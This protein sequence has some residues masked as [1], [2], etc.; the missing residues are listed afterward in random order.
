MIWDSFSRILAEMSPTGFAR[1]FGNYMVS[2]LLRRNELNAVI[3]RLLYPNLFST[4]KSDLI[5]VRLVIH[6]LSS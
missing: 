5:S 4:D 6:D 2:N 3:F 1:F